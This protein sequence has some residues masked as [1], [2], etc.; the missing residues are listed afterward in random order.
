[1]DIEDEAVHALFKLMDPEGLAARIDIEELIWAIIQAGAPDEF[2]SSKAI[3]ETP[4]IDTFL[5]QIFKTRGGDVSI[6]RIAINFLDVVCY[7]DLKV[8]ICESNPL[9]I[10]Q[11]ASVL[12]SWQ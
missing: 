11:T 12:E 4:Q 10:D 3:V 7:C 9:L 5:A 6:F 8:S 1:M 2:L